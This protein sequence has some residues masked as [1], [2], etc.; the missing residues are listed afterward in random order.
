MGRGNF[1]RKGRPLQVGGLSAVTGAETAEPIDLPFRLWT[2]VGRRKHEFN[3]ILQVAPMC[4]IS[5]ALARC[6]QCA[7]MGGHIGGRMSNYFDHLL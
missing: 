1:R 6:R 7:H 3:R 2:L 5:I 4:T